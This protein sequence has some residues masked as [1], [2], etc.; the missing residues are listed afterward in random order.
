MVHYELDDED[1]A[2]GERLRAAL[3]EDDGTEHGWIDDLPEDPG[4]PTKRGDVV[5]EVRAARAAQ[6]KRRLK[7]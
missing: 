3:A 6:P 4:I 5:V 1:R 2:F 7:R